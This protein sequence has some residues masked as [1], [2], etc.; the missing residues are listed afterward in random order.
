MLLKGDMIQQEGYDDTE[1]RSD[2]INTYSFI[3]SL[4]PSWIQNNRFDV[5]G[6]QQTIYFYIY[7]TESTISCT[8]MS[9]MQGISYSWVYLYFFK[10]QILFYRKISMISVYRLFCT[11]KEIIV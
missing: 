11:Q 9:V 6:K 2:F 1:I 8:Q 5:N 3:H 4:I 10:Y 7:G